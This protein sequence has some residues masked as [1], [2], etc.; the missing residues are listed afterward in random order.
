VFAVSLRNIGRAAGR[1]AVRLR[2]GP[3]GAA[4][5]PSLRRI[6]YALAPGEECR[7][8]VTLRVRRGKPEFWL[9]TEPADDTTVPA[10]RLVFDAALCQWPVPSVAA[11][12][13]P[14]GISTALAR[15]SAR[16]IRHGDRLVAEV[17]LGAAPEGLLF[18]A[19]FHEPALRPNPDQ[20]WQGTGFELIAFLPPPAGAPADQPPPKRQVFIVPRG[21]GRHADGLRLAASGARAEPAPEIHAAARPLPGGCEVAAIIPWTALGLDAMPAEFPFELIVDVRDPPTGGTVQA[22]AFDLPWDGWRRLHGR[23][24]VQP[25][26]RP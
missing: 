16:P 18:F 8:E 1:G 24:V 7:R 11:V 9:D 14:D 23:L 10:R 20:P 12:A 26:A 17:K 3:K 25:G 13:G 21:D 2:S 4:G 22:L 5:R 6:G 15:V 19:R